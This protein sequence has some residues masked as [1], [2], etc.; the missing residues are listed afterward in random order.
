MRVKPKNM[1]R[2]IVK[3][4]LISLICLILL[5]TLL[6]L[7]FYVTALTVKGEVIE[8]R[9]WRILIEIHRPSYFLRS[10]TLDK[11]FLYTEDWSSYAV[12]DIV[13]A[14]LVLSNN[15]VVDVYPPTVSPDIIWT[16]RKAAD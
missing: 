1:K 11:V 7:G 13:I 16:V 2:T 6:F 12:G 15:G 5:A 4:I 9:E 8:V 14:T 3:R 10:P